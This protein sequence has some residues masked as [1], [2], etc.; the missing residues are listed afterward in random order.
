MINALCA[1]LLETINHLFFT[2]PFSTSYHNE[3]CNLLHLH[4]YLM[5]IASIINYKWKA[6]CFQKKVIIASIYSLCYYIWKIRNE[7]VWKFC[8]STVDSLF[9]VFVRKKMR[10][11]I[12]FS[13]GAS[14]PRRF[15]LILVVSSQVFIGKTPYIMRLSI[16]AGLVRGRMLRFILQLCVRLRWYIMFGAR[17][18]L[19]FL[20]VFKGQR[21]SLQIWSFLM[22]QPDWMM[23]ISVT[24]WLISF[25]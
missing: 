23:L 21:S 9:V 25:C 22:L 7:A 11:E 15:E 16:C 18:I 24:C 19:E 13:I 2:C 10:I 6:A 12:N 3:L 8:I 17:E 4:N 5:M 20:G 1:S 14:T